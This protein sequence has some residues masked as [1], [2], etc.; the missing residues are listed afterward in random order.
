MTTSVRDP[1]AG[2]VFLVHA[3]SG[4]TTPSGLAWSGYWDAWDPPA[5]LGEGVW[6]TATEAIAWARARCDVVIARVEMPPRFFSAGALMPKDETL[7]EW[8]PADA[9]RFDP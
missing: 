5:I 3:S 4:G 6:A 1:R 2:V 9:D 8:P 7:A